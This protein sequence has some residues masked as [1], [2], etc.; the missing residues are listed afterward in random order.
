MLCTHRVESLTY[1]V[2]HTL[3]QYTY[4]LTLNY[5]V[6]RDLLRVQMITL[7]RNVYEVRTRFKAGIV[8]NK[9]KY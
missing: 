7:Q 5:V 1:R 8:P 2:T 3:M 6:K 9:V 4:I